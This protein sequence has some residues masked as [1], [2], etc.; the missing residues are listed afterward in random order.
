[1]PASLPPQALRGLGRLARGAAPV[2]GGLTVPPAQRRLLGGAA[3]LLSRAMAADQAGHRT[4]ADP[5]HPML[6]AAIRVERSR[7]RR[8]DDHGD[9]TA[10]TMWF[11][12]GP[13]LASPGGGPSVL[14]LALRIG[15]GALAAGA[16]AAASAYA[17]RIEAAQPA[18]RI[19]A[20]Q[21]PR[22]GDTG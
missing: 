14:R 13:A 20:G 2:I 12:Q 1:M 5:R 9:Q 6:P 22:P 4:A 10:V 18:R 15:A 11:G 17:S 8:G 21:P 19:G 3:G 7:F 16:V